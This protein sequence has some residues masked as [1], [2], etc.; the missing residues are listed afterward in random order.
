[1]ENEQYLFHGIS[2]F[3]GTEIISKDLPLDLSLIRKWAVDSGFI[4]DAE[5]QLMGNE[6]VTEVS[7]VF[8]PEDKLLIAISFSKQND[9]VDY[10]EFPYVPVP[11]LIKKNQEV[12]ILYWRMMPVMEDQNSYKDVRFGFNIS[13]SS[14][15]YC[16]MSSAKNIVPKFLDLMN[17]LNN[18]GI[19][20]DFPDGSKEITVDDPVQ[21]SFIREGRTFNVNFL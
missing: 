20:H 11:T 18:K 4:Y 5:F 6:R 16:S 9:K 10:F 13:N 2:F 15:E 21:A 12:E 7:K 1:M 8:T 14:E 19:T 17:E 3:V